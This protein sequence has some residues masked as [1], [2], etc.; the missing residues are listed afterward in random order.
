MTH[1]SVN[2]VKSFLVYIIQ[3]ITLYGAF[4][5]HFSPYV[6]Q[7]HA[8]F[9]CIS[10]HVKSGMIN[11]F[12]ARKDLRLTAYIFLSDCHPYKEHNNM[13]CRH[14]TYNKRYAHQVNYG[15]KVMWVYVLVYRFK[16]IFMQ[17]AYVFNLKKNQEGQNKS[18]N[19]IQQWYGNK[20]DK[21]I[22]DE[23]LYMISLKFTN[24]YMH[25]NTKKSQTKSLLYYLFAFTVYFVVNLKFYKVEKICILR[26]CMECMKLR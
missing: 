7:N 16:D 11:W 9:D 22:A 5:V 26:H 14:N 24:S 19:H 12:L 17:K 25:K 13:D 23:M 20:S 1:N 4:R 2:R 21:R 8:I 10:M 18:G 3:E 6:W 15:I